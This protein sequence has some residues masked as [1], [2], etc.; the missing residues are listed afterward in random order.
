MSSETFNLKIE[1]PWEGIEATVYDG[2]DT[3]V[4]GP[5]GW[6][7]EKDLPVGL[8]TIRSKVGALI[9]EKAIRHTKNETFVAPM[10]PRYTPAVMDGASSSHEYYTGPSIEYSTKL[11]NN[12]SSLFNNEFPNLVIFLRRPNIEFAK[13]ARDNIAEGL[14]L[15]DEQGNLISEFLDDVAR[16]DSSG[17]LALST[18]V[19]VGTYFLCYG[20]G[21]RFEKTAPLYVFDRGNHG[22][23][24]PW[25]T[26]AFV[27]YHQRPLLEDRR[28]MVIRESEQFDPRSEELQAIDFAM[29]A[30]QNGFKSIPKRYMHVL[31]SEKFNNPFMG[32]MALHLLV[33]RKEPN[34]DLIRIV[35]ENT[36]RM[37][38]D[39]SPDM[40]ALSL[41]KAKILGEP[42]PHDCLD[43]SYP[44]LSASLLA[45]IDAS[46]ENNE[47]LHEG[48]LLEKVILN[49]GLNSPWS[50]YTGP[51]TTLLKLKR[52]NTEK[53][54]G[55]SEIR[56]H[57]ALPDSPLSGNNLALPGVSDNKGD[58]ALPDEFSISRYMR[59]VRSTDSI[60][61]SSVKS[62]KEKR[63]AIPSWIVESVKN[64]M[65]GTPKG[66]FDF[67]T[68]GR[69]MGLPKSVVNKI[70]QEYSS[71]L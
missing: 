24:G 46:Y 32:I 53:M 54:L 27:T 57:L 13:K 49:N 56:P 11:T 67:E 12:N 9:S 34:Y 42:L 65:E 14:F 6:T 41:L 4:L 59:P 44:M 3:E 60:V 1:L 66:M 22:G 8:Y 38:G 36:V 17:W 63:P 68:F 26:M 69:D 5:S 52:K 15:F 16:D 35:Y 37:L 7:V 2:K 45:V 31:L 48:S 18:R 33:R 21:K 58:L 43:N 62:R 71:E 70:K 64:A 55:A 29:D 10:P 28:V 23:F 40:K 19:P 30:L 25:K 51:S 50:D 61:A 47:I 39:N 20:K